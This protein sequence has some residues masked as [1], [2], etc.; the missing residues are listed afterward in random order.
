VVGA[1]ASV[2]ALRIGMAIAWR[3]TFT[4]SGRGR[5]STTRRQ[6]DAYID[7]MH[8]YAFVALALHPHAHIA[9]A[10]TCSINRHLTVAIRRVD[11]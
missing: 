5:R 2:V 11:A 1:V 4:Y 8:E 10:Y 3:G 6:D 7:T 9:C